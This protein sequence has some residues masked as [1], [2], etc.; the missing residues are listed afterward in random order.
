MF[1]IDKN[2]IK[3]NFINKLDDNQKNIYKNIVEERRNI[4]FM[5]YGIGFIISLFLIYF[6]SYF[7]IKIN[8][9]SVICFILGITFL[10]TYF[11]YILYPKSNYMI[12]HL[13]NENQIKEWL[14]VYKTMQWNYHFGLVLGLISILFIGKAFC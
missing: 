13:K 11:F 5:G 3:N 9:N 14:K 4:Y 2:E 8:K 1:S 7:N 12:L 6:K 10:T